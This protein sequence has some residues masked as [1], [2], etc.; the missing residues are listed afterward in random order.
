MTTVQELLGLLDT[1]LA[2]YPL[3]ALQDMYKLLYQGILGPEHLI[4]EPE[5]FTARLLAELDAVT[6]TVDEP[7]YQPVRPDRKLLRVNLRPFK[8]LRG[9][10]DRLSDACLEAAKAQWG[11]PD[12][13]PRRLGCRRGCVS[14]RA[15]VA[16]EGGSGV[17]RRGWTHKAILLS[18]TR[19]GTVKPIG[20]RTGSSVMPRAI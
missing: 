7:L 8:A 1:H 12:D 3:M 13:L 10:P 20:R 18:T 19:G 15:V 11:T 17:F 9:D 5:A 2:R 16:S 4:V 14:G 6:P